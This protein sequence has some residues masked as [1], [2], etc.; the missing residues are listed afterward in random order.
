MK[1]IVIFGN[2][3][4]G[5][6]TLAK[7][8]AESENLAHLDLDTIAW[9]PGSPPQRETPEKSKVLIDAFIEGNRGWVIEGCYA[10][11]LAMCLPY[12]TEIIFLNL[13]A[14]LC[15]ENARNRPWESHKYP[16]KEAQDANLNMLIDWIAQYPIRDDVFSMAAHQKL[17]DGFAGTKTMYT[18]NRRDYL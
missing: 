9:Q 8:I 13:P 3:G 12:A 18:S 14:D 10:D 2:S 6:S 16:S 4:S 11:L 17:F 1:K 5:K 7:S 15:I